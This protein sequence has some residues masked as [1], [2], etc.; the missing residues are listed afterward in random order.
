MTITPI[1]QEVVPE[2]A[3]TLLIGSGLLGLAGYGRKKLFKK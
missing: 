3:T 1:R 2:A